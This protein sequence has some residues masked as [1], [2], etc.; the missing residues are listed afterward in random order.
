MSK[1][2]HFEYSVRDVRRA[3]EVIS[4]DLLWTPEREEE[5]RR[6][7]TIANNWRDS[8]A[9]PM[10]SI[11]FS[12]LIHIRNHNLAGFTAARLKRMQAIRRKLRRMR[13][14]GRPLNLNQLQ[15]FGGCRAI[16]NTMEDVRNLVDV[17]KARSAHEF[18]GEDDYIASPKADGYRSHHLKYAFCGRGDSEVHNGRRI[19]VQIRTVLQH[20]WATAIEA[21]GLFRGEDLKGNDGN[22]QWLRLFQL[23]SAEFA[24]AEGCS[25]PTGLPSRKERMEEIKDLEADLDALNALESLSHASEWTRIAVQPRQRPTHYL[26]QYNRDTKTVEVHPY[27]KPL[28]AVEAYDEAENSAKSVDS[29]ASNIVLVEVDKLDNLKRSYPNYFGDV[30]LF[31]SQLRL[32]TKGKAVSEYTVTH[33]QA[34]PAQ[35]VERVDPSWLRR[36]GRWS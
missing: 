29:G 2:P 30:Q 33:Q 4:G 24:E 11:R 19:E 17:M 34:V 10:R 20:S 8:H 9:Y 15:D 23:M 13:D 3:G 28:F 16:M 21:V 6:A 36:R 32:V 18:R 27:N 22:L 25:P 14:R 35:P 31:K 7:F 12:L 26:I 5:I 1:F